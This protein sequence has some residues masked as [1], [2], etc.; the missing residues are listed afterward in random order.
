[1]KR[2]AVIKVKHSCLEIDR[3]LKAARLPVVKVLKEFEATD[4]DSIAATKHIKLVLRILILSEHPNL[5][6]MGRRLLIITN[7]VC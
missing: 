4:R 1:M 7:K 3:F 5:Y 6:E 2:R